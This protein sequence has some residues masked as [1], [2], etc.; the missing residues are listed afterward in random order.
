M[1]RVA[2]GTL[3]MSGGSFLAKNLDT[4]GVLKFTEELIEWLVVED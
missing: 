1:E 2:A 4:L 3:V